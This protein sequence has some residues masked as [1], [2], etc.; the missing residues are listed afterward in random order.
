M[1]R[2]GLVG[3]GAIGR[4]LSGILQRRF[5]KSVRITSLND[6]DPAAADRLARRLRSRP[7]IH[8]LPQLVRESD[9]VIEAASAGAVRA[10]VPHLV[11]RPKPL[12]LLSTGALLVQPELLRRLRRARVPLLIPGGALAGVEA[13]A[14]AAIGR[15]DR[16]R[17]TTRKPPAALPGGGKRQ[18]SRPRLLFRGSAR[19]AA[20]RFPKNINVAATV[21]LAAGAGHRV[22]VQIWADPAVRRNTH[23]LEVAG[24]FGRMTTRVEN[25]PSPENPATSRLAVFSAAATLQRFLNISD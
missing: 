21:A 22:E 2:I 8:S 17:L 7:Q 13:L 6:Q 11:R 20:A 12:L 15:I 18:L 1:V 9:L 25:L 14:A 19:Q 10:L 24:A 16:I 4:E 23:L 3:C 5:P